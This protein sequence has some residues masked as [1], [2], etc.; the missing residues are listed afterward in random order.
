MLCSEYCLASAEGT[1][2]SGSDWLIPLIA[3]GVIVF[4]GA[5]A[6]IPIAIS[7][8]RLLDQVR[9]IIAATILWGIVV[10]GSVIWIASAGLKWSKERRLLV[11]TGYYD[12]QDNSSAPAWP[13]RLWL[14][15]VVVYCGLVLWSL[16]QTKS[17]T[18]M[19]SGSGPA[20]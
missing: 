1:D 15:L 18:T 16:A 19:E 7:R 6:F 8:Y 4:T 17:A 10:A 3:I 11:N 20:E 14:A 9:G 5:L 2:L 13:W 12:P